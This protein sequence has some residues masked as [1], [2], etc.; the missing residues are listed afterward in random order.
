MLAAL[1][2]GLAVV[3]SAPF[4]DYAARLGMDLVLP[5]AT[6]ISGGDD[7]QDGDVALILIDEPTHNAPPF[8]EIPDV[9]WTPYFAGILESVDAAEPKVMG[10]DIIFQKTLGTRDL[11]R[12]FDA[13][14]LR[15]IR[16]S[17]R[18]G[19]LVMAEL[20]LS[21]LDIRPYQAQINVV[22][23][24]NLRS[25]QI[26][27]DTDSVI[28]RHPTRFALEDG[29]TT[30]S[31]A[32]ELAMRAGAADPGDKQFLINYLT[33]VK[34][35][36]AYRVADLHHCREAGRSDVFEAF[37][38]KVVLIGTALDI[39]DRSLAANRFVR[40][41]QPQIRDLDCGVQA[42]STTAPARATVPG[43]L[44]QAFAVKTLL[45]DDA[46]EMI[47]RRTG[48]GISAAIFL[49]LGL[50]FFRLQ[51]VIGAGVYVGAAAL[52]WA[53]AGFALAAG[54]VAP[55]LSWVGGGAVLFA[56][57]YS[58]RT[59]LEDQEK[60]WIRHAFQHYLSPALVDQLADEPDKLRLGGERRNAA[61]LFVDMA[62]FSTLTD[63]LVDEPQTLAAQLNDF[64]SAIAD[65]IDAHDGYVD[66]F[67][68]DCVM[69]VWGAPID[70]GHSEASAARATLACR[71]SVEDLNTSSQR[72]G[73]R[74]GLS[75]GD[76]IAGNL[77]SRNRFNYT[78]VGDAVNI[79]ARLE[80]LSKEYGTTILADEPFAKA[81]DDEFVLRPVDIVILRGRS[82]FSH[83]F[84][85][86][87]VRAEMSARAIADAEAFAG[88]VDLFRARKFEEAAAAFAKW[89]NADKL[90]ALYF[91][92]A[93]S[94]A[95]TPPAKDWNGSL[96]PAP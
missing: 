64:L 66:K 10:F 33:P 76:V 18:A 50:M 48:F 5:L 57:V 11:I 91:E 62:G 56:A 12:G 52:I 43:V 25:V 35:I 29:T 54:I 42:P 21:D 30:T 84:E 19:R 63:E 26:I 77:G 75:T 92:A 31:F 81:L 1:S 82:G 45:D 15:A 93:Q 2:A 94:F 7:A 68:G 55:V 69:G 71:R 61:V 73:L 14:F 38:G 4:S 20:R 74:A 9:A 37:R 96:K 39:E 83:V 3:A 49:A 24:Q 23:E 70:T 13:P 90:S 88:A 44:I 79:A 65:A 40:D 51:P 72:F 27:P 6:A 86:I 60:R 67:I 36:P 87:G 59:F 85:L 46:P 80:P 53:A 22:G 78:V 95:A 28:R 58:Y 89:K 41:R 47:A 32:A 8:S 17:G 34:T 16:Q